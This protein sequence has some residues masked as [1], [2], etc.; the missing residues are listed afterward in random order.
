M[1]P[2][3]CSISICRQY[4]VFSGVNFGEKLQM[5]DSTKII[6]TTT[7]DLMLLLPILIYWMRTYPSCPLRRQTREGK[8]LLLWKAHCYEFSPSRPQ[9]F[10]WDAAQT[11]FMLHTATSVY[12]A[13]IPPPNTP[14]PI[15]PI[16]AIVQLKHLNLF[17]VSYFFHLTLFRCFGGYD[18]ATKNSA[19]HSWL[20]VRSIL[21]IFF[22]FCINVSSK[23][24]S[25][26]FES[27]ILGWGSELISLTSI[28]LYQSEK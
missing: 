3:T 12:R 14:H 28:V 25:W 27:F 2:P 4:K 19:C 20:H 21:E 26:G 10:W 5:I 8:S 18:S 11:W 23:S 15:S 13:V 6:G 22:F 24:Q 17:L 7:D 1:Y 16:P 9:L